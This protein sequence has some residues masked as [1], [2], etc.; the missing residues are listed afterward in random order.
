MLLGDV[1]TSYT[2]IL[3]VEK[4]EYRVIKTLDLLKSNLRFDIA[5]GHN[6]K[7]KTDKVVNELVALEKG[8]RRLIGNGNFLVVDVGSRDI[9]YVKMKSSKYEEMDWNALC[10]ATLGF[11]IE[12]LENHFNVKT[13]EI[14]KTSQSLGVTCGVLGMAKIF[15]KISEG[16]E[17]N[18]VLASFVKGIAENVY[19][20]ID[21]P[22][23]FYLSGGLCN[24]SL[25]VKSFQCKIKP[26]GRFVLLEGLR[27]IGDSGVR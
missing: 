19:K 15:D 4:D 5:C 9:K 22:E 17:I 14:K 21:E 13:S 18:N 23:F 7:L 3:D 16:C 6:A 1:G 25:F 12:L 8:S 11:S 27:E 2:K 24:N 20:F 10:G 26:L